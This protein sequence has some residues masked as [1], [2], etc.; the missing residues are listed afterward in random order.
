MSL[1]ISVICTSKHALAGNNGDYG[2]LI[3]THQL[4]LQFTDLCPT[5]IALWS[6]L[7]ASVL[8]VKLKASWRRLGTPRIRCTNFKMRCHNSGLLYRFSAEHNGL[9]SSINLLFRKAAFVK[10]F[11]L[12]KERHQ[13]SCNSQI[14]R[15]PCLPVPG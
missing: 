9:P 5:W 15:Y 13:S 2:G 7:V 8:Q 12:S 3:H 4:S 1:M 10:S 14:A 6:E 11:L